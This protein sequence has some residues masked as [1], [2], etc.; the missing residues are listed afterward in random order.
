M[1][2]NCPVCN[3]LVGG[4]HAVY[5][6]KH[7][8]GNYTVYCHDDGKVNIYLEPRKNEYRFLLTVMHPKRLDEKYIDTLLLLK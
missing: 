6:C 2:Y 7:Q 3:T 8:F 1:S 5:Y 4:S